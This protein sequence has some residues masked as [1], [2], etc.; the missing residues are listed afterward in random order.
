M[1][2][3]RP[4][5]SG[6]GMGGLPDDRTHG[7]AADPIR[8]TVTVQKPER[9]TAEN[10]R[11]ADAGAPDF[12]AVRHGWEIRFDP[13]SGRGVALDEGT[14]ASSAA[15]CHHRSATNLHFAGVSVNSLMVTPRLPSAISKWSVFDPP[16]RVTGMAAVVCQTP[17]V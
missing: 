16:L 10:E 12:L 17:M 7:R 11:C 8:T 5:S 6:T 1:S 13:E 15:A 9:R 4:G 3:F 2:H 14:R